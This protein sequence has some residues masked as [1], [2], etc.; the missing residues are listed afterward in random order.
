MY[1]APVL[2]CSLPTA[3][4]YPGFACCLPCKTP[5]QHALCR[6]QL[7]ELGEQSLPAVWNAV[8][9]RKPVPDMDA[10]MEA[11]HA[12]AQVL[13]TELPLGVVCMHLDLRTVGMQAL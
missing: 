3:G 4:A 9:G 8:M 2:Y 7:K 1:V 12:I 10:A 6:L 5:C 11:V 13:L